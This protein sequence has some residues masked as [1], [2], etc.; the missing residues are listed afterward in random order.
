MGGLALKNTVTRRYERK[1]YEKAKAEIFAVLGKTFKKFDTPRHF[2]SKESFGDIDIIVSK[3]GLDFSETQHFDGTIYEYIKD[4]FKPNEI[5]VNGNAYSF[6][7]DELQVDI[8]LVEAKD[9]DSNYHYLAFNDLGN[10]MGRI[11][12]MFGIKYGQEGLWYVHE[13]KGQRVGKIMISKDYPEIFEALGLSYE[14]WEKGFDS[15][16]EIF[17]YIVNSPFFDS[18][19]YNLES[20]NKINRDRNA[21]RKSYMSFLEYI[22]ERYPNIEYEFEEKSEYLKYV[23]N[24]F[25]DAQIDMNIKK[26]EY[27]FAQKAYIK[28]KINGGI[29]MKEYGLEG[30]AIGIGM[31]KFKD[32]I[33]VE[34]GTDYDKFVLETTQKE[35][36]HVFEV[37]NEL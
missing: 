3:E 25:P 30:K 35:L 5:F 34:C 22:A 31:A 36:L 16:E 28:S 9:F 14:Q 32:F 26:L 24:R 27:E 2:E 6:N 33:Q 37:A 11:A 12:Q 13:I 23:M 4:T 20:L 21:K 10:F 17:E 7:Y 29:V 8:I 15:L 1:E 19:M 18:K